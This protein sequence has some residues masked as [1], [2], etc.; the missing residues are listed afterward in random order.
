MKIGLGARRFCY[1][2]SRKSGDNA[3]KNMRILSFFETFFIGILS[4][5]DMIQIAED[6][7]LP[8]G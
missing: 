7:S 8:T 2:D 6:K 3:Q 4:S 1:G 5:I